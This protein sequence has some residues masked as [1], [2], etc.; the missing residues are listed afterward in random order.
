[1]HF[2]NNTLFAILISICASTAASLIG[3]DSL[4]MSQSPKNAATVKNGF[5]PIN[6]A[7]N[8][9]ENRT[10]F[11][12]T[13]Q[14]EHAST[15]SKNNSISLN[16]FD[17]PSISMVLPFGFLG[18]FGIGLNQI[19]SANN[20]LE[21]EDET[22]N[23]SFV[24]RVGLYELTPSYSIRLPFFLSDFALGTSY[25]I[26]FGNS[27]STI[28]RSNNSKDWGK[29]SWMAN[30]VMI[31]EKKTG[32]FNSDD[33][34][35]KNFGYSM[36][37]HKK[38]IDYFVSYFPSVKMQETIRENT[39]FSNTD[40][41]QSKEETEDFK[42][43]KHLASGIHYRFWQ[44]QNLSF[45]YEQQDK[46]FSGLA[47]YKI[48]GTGLYY[49]TFLRRNNFG[50]NVWYAEKY[51]K[52]VN[53]YGASLLSDMWLGRRGTFLGLSL[54]GGYRQAKDYWN[55]LFFGFEINLT[56]VGNWGTSARRR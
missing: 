47:E 34:W 32:T 51:L 53:E 22:S 30:N 9:F 14:Y 26:F 18:T 36:H 41:L 44:N 55:E 50:A 40:T 33:S 37:F 31:T 54:F 38:S 1:M 28:T 17:V 56:G 16:T 20:R 42:L 46:A 25:R 3:A 4:G 2:T 48:T 6:P 43:P 10:K 24:S 5:A 11:G 13:I 8:A 21:F 12:A 19:Y 49:S 29:D 15:Q 39:Q 7:A 52:D 27:Y 35:L 45:V 23:I